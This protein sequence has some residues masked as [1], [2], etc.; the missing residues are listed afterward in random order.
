MLGNLLKVTGNVGIWTEVCLTLSHANLLPDDS[1][2]K[3]SYSA[4]SIKGSGGPVTDFFFF[5]AAY[6]VVTVEKT[7]SS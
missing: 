3:T 1:P 7:T 2:S 5:F 4:F 6:F